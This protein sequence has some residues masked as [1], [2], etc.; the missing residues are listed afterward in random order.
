MSRKHIDK[1][2]KKQK[3]KRLK[4]TGSAGKS[5]KNKQQPGSVEFLC[6]ACF[7][8]EDIPKEV[9][10]QFDIMDPGD[11]ADPPRFGCEQCGGEMVPVYYESIHGITHDHSRLKK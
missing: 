2:K 6:K 9:V 1:R 7:I 5:S 11:P 4:A 8:T 3:K 10:T